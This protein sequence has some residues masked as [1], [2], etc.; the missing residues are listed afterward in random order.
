MWKSKYCNSCTMKSIVVLIFVVGVFFSVNAK[1][2][3]EKYKRF[4]DECEA[5]NAITPPNFCMN[6]KLGIQ[7]LHRDINIKALKKSLEEIA[8][9]GDDVIDQIISECKG[10]HGETAREAADNLDNCLIVLLRH[11]GVEF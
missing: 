8:D 11:F 1:R 4:R 6:I 10:V 9:L 3:P 2:I 7:N 5:A